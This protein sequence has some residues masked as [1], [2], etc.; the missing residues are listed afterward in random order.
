ME[1]MVAEA[2]QLGLGLSLPAVMLF[3]KLPINLLAV[4]YYLG[5]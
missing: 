4:L 5:K 2:G 3:G 1:A